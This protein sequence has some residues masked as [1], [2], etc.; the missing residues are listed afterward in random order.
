[1]KIKILLCDTFPGL[2]P[3]F[4]P[5]YVSM[6]TK[7]FDAVESGINYEIYRTMD[8]ELPASTPFDGF[9]L[10]TGCNQSAYDDT[11]WIKQLLHWVVE[12]NAA[13]VT[14]VGVCFGHQV[15]AQALGGKVER[16]PQ[17]WGFGVR[18]SRVVDDVALRF[19]D[20]GRMR[21][22]YNHH[23]QVVALPH[24]ATLVATS[25]FCPIE[26][27]RIA[28]HILTFQGHPEYVPEYETHLLNNFADD[29]PISIRCAAAESLR[30]MSHQGLT[31]AK[32]IVSFARSKA[33][34][35]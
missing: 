31:A 2:L 15:V 7:L 9:C 12:A 20:D 13:G 1:M 27:F 6:F 10:I 16:A 30:Q 22:L 34:C 35:R 26:S 21:L 5:S 19:F 11:P 17:G 3:E 28:D 8:G 23:D 29:E 25:E 32:L 4:I 24:G 14:L 18:E 33:Q